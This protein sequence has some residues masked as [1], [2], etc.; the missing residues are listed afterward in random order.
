MC[1]QCGGTGNIHNS[2]VIYII[3]TETTGLSG[4]PRDH[5]VDIGVAA[6][7]LSTGH[8]SE[9][10]SAIVGY[11]ISTWDEEHKNAWIFKNTDL[12]LDDL[13]S[14]TPQPVVR[15]HIAQ[16]LNNARVTSYNTEFDF[17][18]FLNQEPWSMT[19]QECPDIMIT[20]AEV[21]RDRSHPG[22]RYPRLIHSYNALCP[23]DPVKI[24]GN[25]HHR[26][27]SDAVVAAHVLRRLIDMG[28]YHCE[29]SP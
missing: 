23:D 6:L 14:A 22:G 18:R 12:R 17:G 9:E 2:D 4:A 16:I 21:V 8:I 15:Y 11:D 24:N 20:A 26:A 3:D 27:L 7:N 5:V 1:P 29:V 13:A 10:Y 28:A 19:I 25:Q